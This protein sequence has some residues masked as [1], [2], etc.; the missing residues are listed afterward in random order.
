MAKILR[1][2]THLVYEFPAADELL[3]GP[4]CEHTEFGADEADLAR[5]SPYN[6]G[7]A[8]ERYELVKLLHGRDFFI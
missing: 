1:E 2:E 7:R 6:G 8:A 5:T 3:L 4:F